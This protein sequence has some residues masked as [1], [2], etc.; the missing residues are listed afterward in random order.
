MEG[1]GLEHCLTLSGSVFHRKL[2]EEIA[3]IYG[4]PFFVKF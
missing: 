3:V 2:V 1:K 4:K